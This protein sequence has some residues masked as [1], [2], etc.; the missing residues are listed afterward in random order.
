MSTMA[1]AIK[2]ENQEQEQGL[3]LPKVSPQELISYHESLAKIIHNALKVD[4]DYGMIKGTNKNTL[5]KAG[6]E[7][8]NIAFGTHPE[9]EL[10]EKEL[11]HDREN[12]YFYF[13]K[14]KKLTTTS[15]SFGLYRYVYKCKIVK[16]DGRCIAEA[17]GSCSTLE[18]K[19]ISRPRDMENTVIK[20]A[21][22]RAFVAATLHAFALSDRFTQDMEDTEFEVSSFPNSS[23]SSV[24]AEIIPPSNPPKPVGPPPFIKENVK[25]QAMLKKALTDKGIPLT[26]FDMI[27]DS[28]NGLP[29]CKETLET[30]FEVY[31]LASEVEKVFVTDDFSEIK[32]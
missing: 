2:E 28:I 12:K 11:D 16:L 22:K 13:D 20:M 24:E 3:M 32:P 25:A 15:T 21:Q 31:K 14:Y 19:Y 29:W 4:T 8:L 23:S 27:A 5:Y 9:Y 1:L 18:Q 17:Q 30:A 26:S 6:A 10:V 7:R